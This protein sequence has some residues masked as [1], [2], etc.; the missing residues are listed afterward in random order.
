MRMVRIATASY[1]VDEAPHSVKKNRE[2]AVAY[3]EAAAEKGADVLC[4]P[5]TVLSTNVPA[6]AARYAESYPG[7]DTR[8]FSAAVRRA[9]INLIAPYLVR[10]G[11]RLYSQATVFDR[12]GAV[13][14]IYRKVQPNGAELSYITP[15]NRLPVITLDFG[16]V[17]VMLCMDIYF[18]E[19]ARIYA[20]K[21]VEI[22]F[23]P[24]I[25]HG[26][27][28][29]ALLAQ[30]RARAIDNSIVLVE[31]NLAGAPPYAPY[32]GRA[33]PATGRI[34]DHNGDILAQTGRRP[35]LAIAE[36]DLDEIRLTSECVLLREPDHMRD[37]I[38][39]LIR[40]GLYAREYSALAKTKHR[41]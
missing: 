25:T 32:N 9:R 34:V 41:T 19:I 37:D 26:P 22:L 23:W 6:D 38:H 7:A 30:L 18:P 36:V 8:A 4:L 40:A 16:T 21:G 10:A 12:K 35:G 11:R 17:A 13:A 39:R 3:I 28:Q 1:L 31:S 5:E 33:Y 20:M 27:T 14:G 24:T 2:R 15:G 29:Q